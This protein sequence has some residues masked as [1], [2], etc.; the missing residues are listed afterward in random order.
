MKITRKQLK[1][2]IKEELSRMLRE[3]V[4]IDPNIFAK[5]GD[6]R[7]EEEKAEFEQAILK[8]HGEEYLEALRQELREYE[9]HDA[10]VGID[11]QYQGTDADPKW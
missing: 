5:Y 11:A 10:L 8:L 7:G 4:R 6:L 9:G 3:S 1:R 2:V